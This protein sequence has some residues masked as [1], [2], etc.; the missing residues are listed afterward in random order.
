MANS[1]ASLRDDWPRNSWPLTSQ[2]R[3]S[4]VLYQHSAHTHRFFSLFFFRFI[5]TN[6]S[7]YFTRTLREFV[8]PVRAFADLG[9]PANLLVR[10]SS[11]APDYSAASEAE[12]NGYS[13]A[14]SAIHLPRGALQRRARGQ[15]SPRSF[16]PPLCRRTFPLVFA[17]ARPRTSPRSNSILSRFT[18]S[19][20]S[21]GFSPSRPL[22]SLF[23]LFLSLPVYRRN[24]QC[25][26]LPATP[27]WNHFCF[28]PD[29]RC[30]QIYYCH[31]RSRPGKIVYTSSGSKVESTAHTGDKTNQTCADLF[32]PP[33][34]KGVVGPSREVTLPANFPRSGIIFLFASVKG[35][36]G[37]SQRRSNQC[38][39]PR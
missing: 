7:C 35:Y 27:R 2:Q 28:R 29:T 19:F 34:L 12:C 37:V 17:L 9:C 13:S 14:W 5:R 4:R 24:Y 31:C 33:Q 23:P 26:N 18:F 8:K 36:R 20:P 39:V 30:F 21:L 3:Y 32:T 15:H 10:A 38:S 6:P 22:F 25:L 1:R 16:I 11:F